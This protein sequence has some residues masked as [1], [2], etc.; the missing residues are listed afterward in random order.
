ML[1]CRLEILL[2]TSKRSP[3]TACLVVILK[4]RWDA[5]FLFHFAVS[6]QNDFL[7][8]FFRLL[9]TLVRSLWYQFCKEISCRWQNNGLT[10]ENTY[11]PQAVFLNLQMREINFE[12]L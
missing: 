3:G 11:V 4:A 8:V 6:Q 7:F 9:L 10:T 2:I 5:V 12:K 1:E